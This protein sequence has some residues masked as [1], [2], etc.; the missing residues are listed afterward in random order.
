MRVVLQLVRIVLIVSTMQLLPSSGLAQPV[1]R[2]L[3][4]YWYGRDIPGNVEFDRRFQTAIRSAATGPVEIYSEYLESNKFPG[5]NQRLVLRDYLR[6]KYADRKMDVVLAEGVACLDFLLDFRDSLFSDTPIVFSTIRKPTQQESALAA[7]ATGVVYM[8]SQRET[9]N[10]ALTLHPDTQQVFVISG[11]TDRDK[12]LEWEA[13][14]QLQGYESRLAIT[15]WTDVPLPELVTRVRTLPSGSIILYVW[16]QMLTQQGIVE[17]PEILA[18][19]ASSARVPIYALTSSSIGRGVVGGYVATVE[20]NVAVLADMSRRLANGARAADIPVR[21]APVVPMFDW[22]QLQ[23]WD[24]SEA[25][26]PPHSV[27]RFREPTMWQRYKSTILAA[28]LLF[29]VQAFLIGGLLVQRRRARR[30][31]RE[32]EQYKGHLENLVQ[33]RTTELVKARD[34]AVAAN[35][36]KSTFLS[37]MSHELR[38]PLNSI[39]GFAGLLHQDGLSEKQRADLNVISRSGEH[40][41]GLINDVLDIA[42]I[43]AGQTTA[44]IASCDLG[45]LVVDVTDMMRARAT[46]KSLELQIVQVPEL[47]QYVETD[48]KKLRVMLINLIGNAV[49]FTERGNVTLRL[50]SQPASVP[51]NRLLSFEVQDTG[52]GIALED[53]ERI[54]QPF[55]QAGN[56]LRQKGTGLGLAIARQYAILLGGSLR[57][58]SAPGE[59]SL[60]RL[61]LPARCAESSVSASVAAAEPEYVLASN[62]PEHRVLVVDDEL[63]NQQLLQRLLSFAGFLVQVVDSGQRAI[64]IFQTWRPHF[65]WMDLRMPGMDGSESAQRIRS[66]K[67]G[68]DV[69]IVAVTASEYTHTAEG[70]DDLVHKPYRP[71]DIFETMARHLGVSYRPADAVPAAAVASSPSLLPEAL[72]ALPVELRAELGNAVVALDVDRIYVA[73]QRVSG[74]DAALG[75]ALAL[76]ARRF[77]FS[78][79]FRALKECKT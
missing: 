26:L 51:E 2:I 23:S 59:G 12:Q 36:A 50:S 49:K 27:V 18:A 17:S 73:I 72:A 74:V 47:P 20:G 6:Q 34:Q 45:R 24:I 62:Q 64:E 67:G 65:I 38:T 25:R 54:F 33:E 58:I 41:L 13:R 32:L 5:E 76:H 4:L 71:K 57:V 15:Y 70:M 7:G 56:Q 53:Q 37:H 75:E 68:K 9:L 60:F 69:K 77:A 28:I 29:V 79:I 66:L 30:S 63:E 48:E 3:V 78:R 39:L 19:V 16:Q 44:E 21:T 35:R 8:Q 1:R 31:R 61:E 22:R 46:E 40:L 43:E 42:K 52:I 14:R 10:L 55:V 11:T